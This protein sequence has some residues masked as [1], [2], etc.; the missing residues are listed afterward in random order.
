MFFDS[1][2]EGKREKEDLEPL[3]WN[4]MSCVLEGKNR[5]LFFDSANFTAVFQYSN[6]FQIQ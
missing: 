3:K 5:T 1:E 4:K 6:E 2:I